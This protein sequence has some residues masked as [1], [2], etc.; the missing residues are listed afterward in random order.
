MAGAEGPADAG[1]PLEVGVLPRVQRQAESGG[2]QDLVRQGHPAVHRGELRG[3]ARPPV[4]GTRAW[5][6]PNKS[7]LVL[8]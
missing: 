8:L 5:A 6:T 4:L 3:R 1:E 2:G 7:I